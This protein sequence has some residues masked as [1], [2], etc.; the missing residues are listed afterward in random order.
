MIEQVDQLMQM[1]ETL[2]IDV[3]ITQREL[4]MQKARF[5]KMIKRVANVSRG[6]AGGL[7]NRMNAMDQ[8][9]EAAAT[10][11]SRGADQSD[12]AMVEIESS[13]TDTSPTQSQ[14]NAV[15]A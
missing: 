3:V 6:F 9:R 12:A 14:D 15:A 13:V 11:D 8:E 1:L 4:D 7:R 5:K 2:A 10:S